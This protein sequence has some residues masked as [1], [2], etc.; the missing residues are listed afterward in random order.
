MDLEAYN[1][2]YRDGLQA[3]L[4]AANDLPEPDEGED[5]DEAEVAG[6][7]G[8]S[9]RIE[10]LVQRSKQRAQGAA[11]IAARETAKAS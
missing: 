11:G 7:A 6:A 1:A 4:D 2:G 8:A 5:L 10:A 9:S 3:A